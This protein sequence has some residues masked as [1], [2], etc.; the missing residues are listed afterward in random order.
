VTPLSA[1]GN[2]SSYKGLCDRDRYT[3][4]P[5]DSM[6]QVVPVGGV[7]VKVMQRKLNVVEVD[8]YPSVDPHEPDE[9]GL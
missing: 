9:Q 2:L 1:S 8:E 5:R 3:S 7:K 6:P 4:S